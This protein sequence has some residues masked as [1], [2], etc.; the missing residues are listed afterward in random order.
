MREDAV[1]P[2]WE[3]PV[4]GLSFQQVGDRAI[5]RIIAGGNKPEAY[6]Q[7]SNLSV[8]VITPAVIF[9]ELDL[10]KQDEEFDKLPILPAPAH[11]GR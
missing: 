7:V 9:E 3:E 8:S 11:R 1:D 2:L 4:R 6:N 10:S 5:K